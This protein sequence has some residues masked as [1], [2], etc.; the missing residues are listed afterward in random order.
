[1]N[2]QI[3]LNKK[4]LK[5]PKNKTHT[6][7][8]TLPKRRYLAATAKGIARKKIESLVPSKTSCKLR[9]KSLRNPTRIPETR[10]RSDFFRSDD[11]DTLWAVRPFLISLLKT[12]ILFPFSNN[13]A[14]GDAISVGGFEAARFQFRL[15][16]CVGFFRFGPI[17]TRRLVVMQIWVGIFYSYFV[18]FI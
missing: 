1:M 12:L 18:G 14:S 4:K 2:A 11:D 6:H 7:T 8:L 16:V 15:F 13:Q 9:R 5:N 17:H 10:E 3:N